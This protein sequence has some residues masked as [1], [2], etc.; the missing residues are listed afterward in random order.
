MIEQWDL[1]ATNQGRMRDRAYELAVLPIGAIEPHNYHLP[2][3]VDFRSATYI[4]RRCCQAAWAQCPSILC[5]PAIPYGVDCNL[6]KFPMAIHVSQNT[7]DAMVRDI[8]TSL[9]AHGISKIVLI[10]G[11]GGNEFAAFVRQIQCD[12][13]V[14]VF[15]C[16][17]WAVGR[18]RYDE[19]FETP[20]DHGGEFETSI[21]LV[22]HPEL[23][24]L[25]SAGDGSIRP[26][27]FEAL[28]KGWARTSRDFGRATKTC[29]AGDP[30]RATAEKGR[31]YLDLVCDRI[32]TFLVELARSPVDEY[33]PHVP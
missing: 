1:T 24:E 7:L 16:N 10:N 25:D 22:I 11:H 30:S 5:L 23:V 21:S 14:H 27:R 33:F 28:Q 19:I 26:F 8:I 18:D 9:R 32:T 20:D 15:V 2:E 29:A 17:W 12:V 4:A 6:M 3:G 31:R 13:D